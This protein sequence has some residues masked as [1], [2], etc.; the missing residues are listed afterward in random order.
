MKRISKIILLLV[1]ILATNECKEVLEVDPPGFPSAEGFY[2]SAG[3]AEAGIN[4]IYQIFQGDWWGGAFVHIQ[5]HF[6]AV[7][8]NAVVCC[9]WEYGITAI[10]NGTLN[11]TSGGFAAWKWDFGYQ[12]IARANQIMEVIETQE[13]E[14]MTEELKNSYL[15]E[16]RFLRAYVYA[17]ISFFYGDAPLI[18]SVISGEEAKKIERTPK[19]QV[20]A[21]LLEDLD[22]AIANLETEP[23]NGEFGR[24]TKQAALALKGK[25]LLYN[26]RYEEAATTLQKVI[27]MEGSVVELDPDYESLFRGANEESKEILFSIQYVGQE[28]GAGEGSFIQ[29]HYAPNNLDGTSASSGQGWGSFFYTRKLL[30]DYYMTDGLDIST[31]PLYDEDSPFENR[32]P[33]FKMTFFTPGDT[34]RGVVLDTTNFMVNGVASE[35][36]MAARKWATDTDNINWAANSS[37]DLVVMRYADVLMMYAEAQ[38]EA[39]GPDASVYVAV[40]KI[41][42]R[43]EMPDFPDGL[44]KEEMREEIKHERKIEFMMEG[45]HYFDLLRW[46]DAETVIPSIPDYE[47][48]TFDP[49]KNYLWPIPQ[50][51]RDQSPNITQN[52]GY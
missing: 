38:N 5:P 31:S 43:A 49:A 15:A 34:Y 8:E 16:I 47:N 3:D 21:A 11:P 14:G 6:E 30:D 27:D 2:K 41:R 17:E 19:A 51:A 32:D 33:R 42:A 44:N 50:S 20:V 22:F 13:L 7:T 12:A 35:I 26:N 28:A 46:R 4:G 25:V 39:A 1:T 23:R 10:A 29:T 52:P 45:H 18:L 24:P 40:N 48:R 37:A 9:P 36:P